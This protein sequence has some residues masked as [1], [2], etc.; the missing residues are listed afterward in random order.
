MSL[1]K[2]LPAL[3]FLCCIGASAQEKNDLLLDVIPPSPMAY[4]MTRFEAQ[5]PDL[6]TGTASVSIPLHTI[7]FDGWQLPLSLSYRA[8]G[9]TTNQEATEVGLGWAMNATAVISRQVKSGDDLVNTGSYK[10]YVYDPVDYLSTFTYNNENWNSLTTNEKLSWFQTLKNGTIDTEPDVFNYNFFGFSGSFAL[11]KVQ[12][13][14]VPVKKITED[15]VVITFDANNESFTLVTPT[16]YAGSFTIKEI[17]T[18]LSGSSN[19]DPIGGLQVYSSDLASGLIDVLTIKNRGNFR[20]VTAWYVENIVSPKGQQLD[21]GYNISTAPNDT[22]AFLSVSCPSFGEY[23]P[24]GGNSYTQ[25]SFTR[26]VQEHVYLTSI[27]LANELT[28]NFTMEDRADLQENDLLPLDFNWTTQQPQRYTG[29][30]ITSLQA[31]SSLNKSILFDQS[32]FNLSYLYDYDSGKEFMKYQMLRGRLDRVSI[33]D[34]VYSFQYNEGLKGLPRKSTL[35]IDYQGFYNG[36]DQNEY[37][38][39]V[40]SGFNPIGYEVSCTDVEQDPN[41]ESYYYEEQA[42]KPDIDFGIAGSLS[43]VIYP[44]KGFTTFTY[45]PHEYYAA[46]AAGSGSLRTLF[47]AVNS[48]GG[49]GTLEAGG[50]RIRDI[51]SWDHNGV[52]ASRKTYKYRLENSSVSSGKLM[53]PLLHVGFKR[54]TPG[55]DCNY[56]LQYAKS[57][58]GMNTAKGSSIGYDRVIE[59]V[60]NTKNLLESYITE[61]TYENSPTDIGALQS[62]IFPQSHKNGSLKTSIGKRQGDTV[63]DKI[64][65]YTD[66]QTGNIGGLGFSVWGSS[67]STLFAYYPYEIPTGNYLSGLVTET[68][69]FASG[70]VSSATNF[71]Y[72]DYSQVKEE[73]GTNSL[74]Q[75][76][77]KVYKRLQDYTND[78]CSGNSSGQPCLTKNLME[79]QN[80]VSKVLEKVDYVDGTVVSA[81]GYRYGTEHGNVVLREVYRYN[82]SLGG[83]APSANGFE[84]NGSYESRITY[85]DYDDEGNLLQQTLQDGTQNSFVW[86]YDQMYPIVKGENVSYT[87]LLAAYQ[88][89]QDYTSLTGAFITTYEYDPL[90]GLVKITDPAGRSSYFEYDEN[91]RLKVIKD[92]D[93]EL[94]SDY[95]YNF[96]EE[97]KAGGLATSTALPFGIVNP[98]TSAKRYTTISNSGNYGITVTDLQ[99]PAAYSSVWDNRSFY[100]PPGSEFDLPVT[101][102]APQNTGNYNGTLVILSDDIN[103]ALSVNLNATSDIMTTSLALNQECFIVDPVPTAGNIV[104]NVTL[105]N[106]GNS[107]LYIRNISTNDPCIEPIRWHN[108]RSAAN[109]GDYVLYPGLPEVIGLRLTCNNSNGNWDDATDLTINYLDENNTLTGLD[110]YVRGPSQQCPGGNPPPNGPA[111]TVSGDTE[112]DCSSGMSGSITVNS[113]SIIVT[114]HFNSIQSPGGMGASITISGAATLT[115]G[116]SQVITPTSYPKTYTFSSGNHTCNQGFGTTALQVSGN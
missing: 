40:V 101:F 14:V 13:G 112:A 59:Q 116:Q 60:E 37:M 99:L 73:T 104:A 11:E 45:E 32:Y 53:L 12:N 35:G 23:V 20:T 102:N 105:I 43:K 106:D 17:S 95:E 42:R 98:N 93:Q 88:N 33:D 34:R 91:R 55:F 85:D 50:L 97:D 109:G 71:V 61:Y 76:I 22:S 28:V 74:G 47:P 24:K 31:S 100:L 39:A 18:N 78:P 114:N 44:T 48:S 67:S 75:P 90:V 103:G 108:V 65:N 8:S 10:G 26:V 111:Y 64:I 80:Q 62:T 107:P 58:P 63:F 7:D 54:D 49:T 3:A 29:I 96:R 86:G 36:M 1:I 41:N 46:G 115:E 5:Q 68:Q 30:Q 6:Y 82:R 69:H 38:K 92:V 66:T 25:Q 77:K 9:I 83:H 81:T 84:F 94:V 15:G 52:L 21:F 57:I 72:D 79:Q 89:G 19:E 51:E 70:D 56:Y 4:E 16:G 87:D 27:T 110:F 113:G 2:Y